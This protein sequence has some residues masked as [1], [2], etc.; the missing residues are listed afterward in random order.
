M[1]EEKAILKSPITPIEELKK[2]EN[3]FFAIGINTYEHFVPLNNARK[4]VEDLANLLVEKYY[5]DNQYMR[6]LCDGEASKDNIIDELD[7]LRSKVKAEDRL[8]IYYSG[9]GYME[10]ERGFWI[11]VNAKRGRISSYIANAEIRDIIQSIK[12]RHILLISDS[13]FLL[14]F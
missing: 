1:P 9:H 2:G 14:P 7:G 4:D 11:P 13:C 3:H 6:M 10:E 12:A 5:F 8:L